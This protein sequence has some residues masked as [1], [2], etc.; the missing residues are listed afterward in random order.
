MEYYFIMHK[1]KNC[2]VSCIDFRIQDTLHKWLKNHK[3]L[4]NSDIITI[5][6]SS[7]DIVK[8]IRP[9]DKEELLRNITLSVE[10]HDPENIIIFDHQDC[11]GYAQDNTIPAELEAYRDFEEHKKFCEKAV[12]MLKELFPQKNVLAYFIFLDGKVEK[13]C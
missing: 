10:L 13:L 6:G 8:P 1:A 5:A 3:D 11:G 4:G 7:R 12:K 2:I 9:E